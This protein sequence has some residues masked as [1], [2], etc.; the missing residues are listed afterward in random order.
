MRRTVQLA[1]LAL[2]S[3]LLLAAAVQGNV[4]AGRHPN[5]AAAQR[6]ID[7]AVEKV[8]A[9]QAANEF[10]M[11]GHGA[12]AKALLE[13]AREELKLAAEAANKNKGK[14]G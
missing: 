7:Q 5:L 6:L 8:S 11:E 1:T 3:A 12:K 4:N 14:K 13:Q 9:A 2:G 10:D